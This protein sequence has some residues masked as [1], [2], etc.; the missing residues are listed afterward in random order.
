MINHLYKIKFY[1]S[2]LELNGE[3]DRLSDYEKDI[4]SELNTESFL[5]MKMI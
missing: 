4:V 3:Y 2:S 1:K 5:T